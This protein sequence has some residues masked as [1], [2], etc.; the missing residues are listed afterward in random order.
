LQ[1]ALRAASSLIEE[2]DGLTLT[3]ESWEPWFH[4]SRGDLI[5][6]SVHV[7]AEAMGEEVPIDGH[8]RFQNMPLDV[9]YP[10]EEVEGLLRVRR[11]PLARLWFELFE[12]VAKSPNAEAWG[13]PVN[14]VTTVFSG[15]SDGVITSIDATYST[16]AAGGGTLTPQDS[17]LGFTVGHRTG[18]NVHEG[19]LDFDTSAVGS[20]D[21]SQ[22]DL[23]LFL[24]QD[25]STTDFT[26]NVR[27]FDFGASIDSGD[28]RTP[29]QLAALTLLATFATSGLGAGY[30]TFSENGTS[31]Q[32]AIDGAGNTRLVLSSSRHESE[33]EPTGSEYVLFNTSEKADTTQDP[34]LTITHAAPG[35]AITAV[36]PADVHDGLTTGVVITGT[37]FGATQGAGRVVISPTDDIDDVGA[38]EPAIASWGDTQITLDDPL[39][40]SALTLGAA[41]ALYVFVEDDAAASNAA[42]EAVTGHAGAYPPAQTFA[43]NKLNT[44]SSTASVTVPADVDGGIL[45]GDIIYVVALHTQSEDYDTD[46]FALLLDP[47]VGD[48]APDDEWPT[49]GI[50]ATGPWMAQAG[51]APSEPGLAVYCWTA[52]GGEDGDTISGAATPDTSDMAGWITICWVVR[53]AQ[54]GEVAE[55]I[56]TASTATDQDPD[57]PSATPLTEYS[58]SVVIGFKDSVSTTEQ[59]APAAQTDYTLIGYRHV[60][61]SVG[62]HM[63]AEYKLLDDGL[64]AENPGVWD[65]PLNGDEWGAVH[66][67]I[68][69]AAVTNA[70]VIAATVAAVL[71]GGVAKQTQAAAIETTPAAASSA[72]VAKQTIPSAVD[73]TVAEVRAL[74]QSVMVPEAA[75]G[76]TAPAPRASLVATQG[77]PSAIETTTAATSGALDAK[78]EIPAAVAALVAAVADALQAV[79]TPEAAIDSTVAAVQGGLVSKQTVPAAIAAVAAAVL[80]ALAS[81]QSIA[82]S[83]D[84]TV[85]V[86]TAALEA[87]MVPEAAIATAV[88]AVRDA[89]AATHG[90]PATEADIAAVVAAVS[91]ALTASQEIPSTIATVLGAVWCALVAAESL[92]TVIDTTAAPVGGAF[93]ARQ[94]LALSVLTQV[95]A[96][97]GSLD[98]TE[99]QR[100]AIASLVAAVAFSGEASV[101]AAAL[102]I[103]ATFLA[104]DVDVLRGRALDVAV[105]TG[106]GLDIEALSGLGLDVGALQRLA[107][108]VDV[109]KGKGK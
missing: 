25:N 102:V 104:L 68:R 109:M 87:V 95:A 70:A 92:G 88:A 23:D 24:L 94:L 97:A 18:F 75:V 15:A 17:G 80:A 62:G 82:L 10:D 78:Q 44:A 20:D 63:G 7:T 85:A 4:P 29:A 57:P 91:D 21:V 48:V 83:V 96:V 3:I 2:R 60:N 76:T 13:L 37:A 61:V 5:G 27:P 32:S 79:M 22:V 65:L 84:T 16:A 9:I 105:L 39:D 58:L 1:E 69:P 8:R 47:G 19:F 71:F 54:E 108:D 41:T 101:G 99:A 59:S 45:A 73:A 6:V 49:S 35:P 52:Q 107:A 36:T 93:E 30:N 64:T 103:L 100:A 43:T 11:D 50:G 90:A 46:H 74:L 81:K 67:I 33:T 86:V 72:L 28:W 56:E 31:F 42:G 106:S 14:T 40:L 55:V 34:K 53:N 51:N 77:I 12:S 89:L 26:I 66:L 38:I 98:A